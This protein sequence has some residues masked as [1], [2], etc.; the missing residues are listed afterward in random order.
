MGVLALATALGKGRMDIQRPMPAPSGFS[1]H[2]KGE[3]V[4]G[5]EHRRGALAGVAQWTEC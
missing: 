5:K 2:N 3:D 4:Y 1:K